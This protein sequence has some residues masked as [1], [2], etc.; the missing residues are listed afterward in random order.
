MKKYFLALCFILSD[1][2]AEAGGPAIPVGL[3]VWAVGGVA[4]YSI[5]DAFRN[6]GPNSDHWSCA[7]VAAAWPL[8]LAAGVVIWGASSLARAEEIPAHIECGGN[9]GDKQ[10]IE[11]TRNNGSKINVIIE[12]GELKSDPEI[13]K[14]APVVI[15]GAG[16]IL[17]I[18]CA[19]TDTKNM[20]ALNAGLNILNKSASATNL[21][22]PLNR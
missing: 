17:A 9:M 3:G 16:Q 7:G 19:N 2:K 8:A 11:I 4:V 13:T 15:N 14:D 1:A 22:R 18:G 5:C 10:T 21:G 6:S 20:E 12:N